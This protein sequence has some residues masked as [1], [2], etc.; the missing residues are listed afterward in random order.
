MAA[1][2]ITENIHWIGVNDRTTDLF[3]G[4]WPITTEGVSYN[5]YAIKDEKNVL[6]DL[7]KSL[8]TD[9]FIERINE[10]FNLEEL[11]Y[12]ILNHM[13]PDHTG[14]LEIIN[15]IS[16]KA[17]IVISAKAAQIFEDFFGTTER[18]MI[19]NDGD[20]LDLG[21]HKLTFYMTPM[22][23]WPE[24]MMTYENTTATLFSCDGFGGYGA[25]CG[26]IFDDQAPNMDF[27]IE[28][29]LRYYANIVAK[30][31]PM[32]T[33]AIQKLVDIKLDIKTIAPSHGLI[34]RKNPMQIV[35]L[36]LKW[37]SYATGNHEKSVSVL[38][39]SMYG[40]TEKF[41]NS[42]VFGLSE[43]NVDAEVFDVARIHS[44]YILPSMWKN[45][46]IIV[47]APT[48]EAELFPPA[49]H[50]LDLAKR[51]GIKNRVTAY[52]GSRLW[53]GG[54]NREFTKWAEDLKWEVAEC[55]E[56]RGHAFKDEQKNAFNFGREFAKKIK[57]G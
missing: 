42:L 33:K 9:E 49:V 16:Q 24:T 43:E 3:E 11:D 55:H 35:E 50:I 29:S 40:N 5:S 1:V 13:E 53:S 56:F 28:Q 45:K 32:V 25:L 12:I 54:G 48:Y 19:V 20:T 17:K 2:E 47:C 34:W 6:I 39:G 7:A 52:Y 27:Y 22:V 4:L 21:K 26:Y 57:E 46:G 38:Y 30:Y 18:L 51:K 31:S 44:S 37:A 23:H 15:R 8:K 41:M 10:I 14:A 36:Y